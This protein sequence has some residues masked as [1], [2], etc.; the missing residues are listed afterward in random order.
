MFG[1]GPHS[2]HQPVPN[3][4]FF[5]HAKARETR[6]LSSS[7]EFLIPLRAHP[8]ILIHLSI[9]P[10][11]PMISLVHGAP[12]IYSP[13]FSDVCRQILN[14]QPGMS[15]RHSVEF[16]CTCLNG[17]EQLFESQETKPS[18]PAHHLVFLLHQVVMEHLRTSR[19]TY[20]DQSV[21]V[22]S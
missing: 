18:I 5:H 10:L 17:L 3:L 1:P 22:H 11:I 12:L 19:R 7:A 13:W 16:C 15:P 21:S 20:L 14:W 4:T 9:Q 8:Y 6:P 2:A